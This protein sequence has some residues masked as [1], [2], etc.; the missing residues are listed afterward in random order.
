M[1]SRQCLDRKKFPASLAQHV[2]KN[3]TDVLNVEAHGKKS[4]WSLNERYL[5]AGRLKRG[6][7][8]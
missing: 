4:P 3:K 1:F 7:V 2:L 6:E 8:E 5:R